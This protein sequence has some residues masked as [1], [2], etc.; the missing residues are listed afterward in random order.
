[1]TTLADIRST[2]TDYLY[3]GLRDGRCFAMAWK[4]TDAAENARTVRE[5]VKRGL[6][7]QTLHKDQCRPY[8]EQMRGDAKEALAILESPRDN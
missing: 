5:W 1:V 7:V 8:W 6:D 3:V 4:M 2:F